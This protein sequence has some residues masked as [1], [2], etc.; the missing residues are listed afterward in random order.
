MF[1]G[2][3]REAGDFFWELCF[4]NER[5]WFHANKDRFDQLI[6]IPMKELAHD[7]DDL[8]RRR[9]PLMEEEVHVSRIW[10]DAR[11][12]Y[13]RG[14]LKEN[15]WFSIEKRN[16]PDFAASFF[17]ELQPAVFSYGMGFWCPHSEQMELFR[18]SI[19]ANPAA[20]ER[21]ASQV[22]GM[23]E[24]ELGGPFYK[25]PKG[26]YGEAV[27]AWYNRKW[28]NV[29]HKEDFGGVLLTPEMPSVLADAFTKLMPMYEY[30]SAH[31]R[32][33]QPHIDNA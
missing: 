11:R 28:T 26:D 25:R 8:L 21:L 27:N 18:R 33:Q 3:Q 10:R 16:A 32:L 24:F 9:F 14:P 7:T 30:V 23:K 13:G 17:F 19:D 12:L 22:A 1:Q 5:E 6:G 29:I 31:T 15:L 4:H 2:F 20:F